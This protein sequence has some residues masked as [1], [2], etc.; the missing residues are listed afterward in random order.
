MDYMAIHQ[1]IVF[2]PQDTEHNVTILIIDDN[3]LEEDEAFQL[4]LSVP[5]GEP[6]TLL[7]PNHVAV[8]KI[9]NDDGKL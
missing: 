2:Q 7:Q 4:E 8:I 3:V 9:L 1:R 5:E 6:V